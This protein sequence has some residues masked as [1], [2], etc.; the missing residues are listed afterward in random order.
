MLISF[1]STPEP[2]REGRRRDSD[3]KDGLVR[4]RK[5][6]VGLLRKEAS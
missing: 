1:S 4:G 2:L 3:G 5:R 6:S